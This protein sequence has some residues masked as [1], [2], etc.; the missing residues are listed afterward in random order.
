MPES[1]TVRGEGLTVELVLHRRYG[2]RG[3]ELV[4]D[5]FD[6]NPGLAGLGAVL[7]L[8]TQLLI[9]DLPQQRTTVTRRISLFR[10]KD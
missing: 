8:G 4:R 5:A 2:V 10:G 1:F 6:L 9:P 7:P 3:R